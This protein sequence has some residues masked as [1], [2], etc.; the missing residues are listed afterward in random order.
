MSRLTSIS[1]YVRAVPRIL[2]VQFITDLL[3]A[4]CAFGLQL[5]AGW[6][7]ASQGRV[8]VTT[9]DYMFL[10]TSWQGILLIVLALSVR[11]HRR[12]LHGGLCGQLVAWKKRLGLCGAP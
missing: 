8:A 12:V 6:A 4:L 1:S 2:T 5:L 11:R 10:F 9:G 3:F 7:L